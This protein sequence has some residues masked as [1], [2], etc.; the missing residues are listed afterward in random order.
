VVTAAEIVFRYHGTSLVGNKSDPTRQPVKGRLR[1]DVLEVLNGTRE[2]ANPGR[3]TTV[4][5]PESIYG[6]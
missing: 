3:P 2:N 6:R 1:Q 5:N 4:A